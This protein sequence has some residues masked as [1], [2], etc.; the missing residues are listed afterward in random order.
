MKEIIQKIEE[1]STDNGDE[2]TYMAGYQITTNKRVI[3]CQ[4]A[5]Y[6]SCCENY[7]YL[8]SEDNLDD[9]IGAEL[10][11]VTVTDTAL[12]TMKVPDLYELN[13]VFVNVE[14]DRGTFQIAVYNSHNGYYG[15]KTRIQIGD[16]VQYEVL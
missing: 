11:D 10:K 6:Q 13:A 16:T 9:F 5:D 15:H 14:T 8:S 3:S 7:G 2:Y 4:I 1:D 12:S